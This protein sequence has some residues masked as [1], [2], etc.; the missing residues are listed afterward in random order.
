MTVE[1]CEAREGGVA[2]DRTT[3]SV[4]LGPR[5][6]QQAQA[7][8]GGHAEKDAAAPPLTP[9]SGQTSVPHHKCLSFLRWMR[10][11]A[12]HGMICEDRSNLL[13]CRE[14]E[15]RYDMHRGHER[16]SSVH[17]PICL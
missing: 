1:A 8:G 6:S 9:S 10:T 12:Y 7:G 16:Q 11:S 4:T 15:G 17:P 14:A 13:L 2:F 5:L 3:K